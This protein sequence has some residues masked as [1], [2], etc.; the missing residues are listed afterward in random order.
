MSFKE[1]TVLPHDPIEKLAPNLWSVSGSM[2]KGNQRRMT[3]ARLADGRLVVHNAVALGDSEMQAIDAFGKVA[4]IVVPNGFHRQDAG[5]FKQRYPDAKVFCPRGALGK[6][7]QVVPVDGDYDAIPQD[8]GVR[9]EHLAGMAG[10]EGVLVVRTNGGTTAVF[11]DAVLNMP[12]SGG[13]MG[14][15]LAPTGLPSVPRVTRWMMLKDKAAFSDHLKRM[16]GDGL[17]RVIV[18]HGA[19]VEQDAASV[20][21]GVAQ[22]VGG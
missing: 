2:P 20:L 21:T 11:N 3:I 17:E 4:A 13:V 5:I 18:G 16:A 1:W 9:A 19:T 22:Q 10:K 15:L 14:F 8:D 7:K 12:A 6:V